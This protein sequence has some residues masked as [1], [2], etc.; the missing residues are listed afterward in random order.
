[1]EGGF[2]SAAIESNACVAR[3][4]KA[5]SRPVPFKSIPAP[6]AGDPQKTPSTLR[7]RSQTDAEAEKSSDYSSE[8]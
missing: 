2:V 3:E 6:P 7:R 5:I 4:I 1:L 8:G